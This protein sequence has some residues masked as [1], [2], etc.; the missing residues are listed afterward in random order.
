MTPPSP[1]GAPSDERPKDATDR[2]RVFR[3]AA[4]EAL[5]VRHSATGDVGRLFTGEGLEV[6]WVS[7]Q[8]EEIDPEWF[9]LRSVDLLLVLQ[10]RLRMEFEDPVL[11]P[12]TLDP[13]DLVV[14]PANVRCRAYRW[15]RDAASPTVFLAV[16]PTDAS[17]T[18]VRHGRS[19]RTAPRSDTANGRRRSTG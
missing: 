7:K 6:V 15:P 9:S 18:A 5:D 14:L 17:S 10:G 19:D 11:A 12:I 1:H 13:L 16:Y 2:P 4:R 3:L 8:A